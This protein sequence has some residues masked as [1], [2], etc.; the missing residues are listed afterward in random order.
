MADQG[1]EGPLDYEYGPDETPALR[2]PCP[3][4]DRVPMEVLLHLVAAQTES[5]LAMRSLLYAFIG[6][7]PRRE[8]AEG[9]TH[10]KI[11]VE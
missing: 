3:I 11:T 10:T 6:R 1:P 2:L 5:L 7:P 4:L 9:R 8:P